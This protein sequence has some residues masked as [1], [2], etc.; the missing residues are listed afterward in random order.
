MFAAVTEV[1]LAGWLA[2]APVP[3]GADAHAWAGKVVFRKTSAARL[4][5]RDAA[6][7][8]TLGSPTRLTYKVV[9]D[10]GDRVQVTHNFAPAWFLKADVV[11]VQD[12]V[13][14]FSAQIRADPSDSLA[15]AYRGWAYR[16]QDR[17]DEA[18]RDYDR[19][20]E[21][22]PSAAAWWNNR[23]SIKITAGRF[24]DAIGDLDKAIG[25]SPTAT[26]FQN[27]GWAKVMLKRYAAAAA[28]LDRAVELGPTSAL[29][30]VHRA[31]ARAGLGRWTQ[32]LADAEEAARREPESPGGWNMVAWLKA[33]CPDPAVRDGGAAVT[34]AIR[35]CEAARWVGGSYL[36]TLAAAYAEAG[37]FADAARSQERALRDAKFA[38]KEGKVARERLELYRQGKPYRTPPPAAE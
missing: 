22:Q 15:Y 23:A 17:F 12:A 26:A 20:I 34:A 37:R 21:L 3:K 16:E 33:T 2:A 5:V 32:A 7:N 30:F 27:R 36:D 1:L 29:A 8:E 9:R 10:E 6:G 24:E 11:R 13:A 25:I 38:D 35:A 31:E 18:I 14:H 4:F 19:A 28:D